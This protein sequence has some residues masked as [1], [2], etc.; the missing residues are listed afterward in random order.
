MAKV[1]IIIPIYNAERYLKRCLNSIIKQ[2]LTDIEIVLVNDGSTDSSF[3][4]ARNFSKM[5]N[6]FVLINSKEN[7]GP[8]IAR[9]LGYKASTGDYLFFCDS[10]DIIP[11][12]AIEQLY[13]R[14]EIDKADIIIGDYSCRDI[15][16]FETYVDRSKQVGDCP[17]DMQN[18]I[19]CGCKCTLWGILYSRNIF[20]D[21]IFLN[22]EYQ[23]L[24]EDRILMM[25]ILNSIKKISVLSE[26]SYI[27]CQNDNSSTHMVPSLRVQ[28][29]QLFALDWIWKY[30]NDN[31]MNLIH[32]KRYI[33]NYL[34]YLLE[35]G[36]NYN[37]V[38]Y[39]NSVFASWLSIKS[40]FENFSFIK[41]L[42]L[43]ACTN[44]LYSRY[45]YSIRRLIRR[46][47]HKF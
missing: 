16:G 30:A 12:Y 26:C 5:D 32:T 3:E 7:K 36:Y 2:S 35:I 24:S 8:M 10:D 41:A 31:N 27:Y 21:H 15:N 19:L 45:I 33:I 47:Q 40:L 4:I 20:I 38:L 42:H 28:E 46:F 13:V 25:Q 43:K 9:E 11:E 44:R 6:R 34:G 29:S 1:S 14:I 17:D 22:Y 37:L 23:I 39:Y 18:S